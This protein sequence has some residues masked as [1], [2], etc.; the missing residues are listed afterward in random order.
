MSSPFT[1]NGQRTG[2]QE[3]IFSGDRAY[4]V[5]HDW[6]TDSTADKTNIAVINVTTGQLVDVVSA[7]GQ[8]MG[9]LVVDDS[10]GRAYMT[11]LRF[12]PGGPKTWVNVIDTEDGA[13]VGS[14]IEIDGIGI[15]SVVLN[16]DG[17]RAYQLSHNGESGAGGAST[18]TV[19]NTTTGARDGTDID[20]D[21]PGGVGGDLVLDGNTAGNEHAYVTTIN[22]DS[23]HATITVIDTETRAVVDQLN[24]I[25]GYPPR[26][27]ALSDNGKSVYQVFD[28][29]DPDT[30]AYI[31]RV[32][33]FNTATGTA[34]G[35]PI[36]IAGGRADEVQEVGD[37]LYVQTV[38]NNVN[39]PDDYD[40]DT[41]TS[42]VAVINTQT[43]Q[44]MSSPLETEGGIAGD[45][46]VNGDRAYQ[47]TVD[48]ERQITR[49]TVINTA[50]GARVGATPIEINGIPVQTLAEG[51]TAI[52][53]EA[54]LMFDDNDRA[55]QVT[56]FDNGDGT[57][58]MR[59]AVINTDTGALVKAEPIA[60]NGYISTVFFN[61][62]DDDR[63]YLVVNSTDTPQF[64]PTSV[65]KVTLVTLDSNSGEVV[66]TPL[67]KDGLGFLVTDK[68]GLPQHLLSVTPDFTTIGGG[69]KNVT[70]TPVAGG[71]SITV[72][73]TA[74]AYAPSPDGSLA[75]IVT[76]GANDSTITAVDL[77]N[78]QIVATS[79]TVPGHAGYAIT[80]PF[81]LDGQGGLVFGADGKGY[82]TTYIKNADGSYTTQVTGLPGL[83]P[84][85]TLMSFEDLNVIYP[86]PEDTNPLLVEQFS[87]N[88]GDPAQFDMNSLLTV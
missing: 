83:E 52:P 43:G 58:T 6:T 27:L 80:P 45:I 53:R 78:G 74:V 48:E 23:Q 33:V 88:A 41:V 73:G 47:T 82:L 18:I 49:V 7:D 57:S 42:R 44:L 16:R 11:T 14:P 81:T 5:G 70:F 28:A 38:Q 26:S 46:I 64:T 29:T 20:V 75:Y 21:V 61:V 69:A 12:T 54:R 8:P 56:Q 77:V 51:T 59:V 84:T 13:L 79:S 65:F 71:D 30:G 3:I 76:D 66:G 67:T 55:Y 2:E 25:N 22:P 36:T 60:I 62:V 19:I 1:F 9:N 15:H 87:S 34:V 37:R 17:S 39:D 31:T 68:D 32:A 63:A 35:Q 85:S 50:T 40:D 86:E 4:L 72:P 24:D 10:T